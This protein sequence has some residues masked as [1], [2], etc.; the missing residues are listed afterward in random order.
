MVKARHS[1]RT[2]TPA[3]ACAVLGVEK[4]DEA[5]WQHGMDA[6]L[7]ESWLTQQEEQHEV[8]A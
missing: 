7:L 4:L 3:H 1:V 2:I 8:G 6:L 5:S